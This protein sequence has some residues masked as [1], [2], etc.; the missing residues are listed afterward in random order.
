MAFILA[1]FGWRWGYIFLAV[2]CLILIPIVAMLI[3]PETP[4]AQ[5]AA[6]RPGAD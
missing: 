2:V 1:T 4:G 5:Q 3:K 6:G